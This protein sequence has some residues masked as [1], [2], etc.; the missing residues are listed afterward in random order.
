[1]I[2]E[3]LDY[4]TFT[5]SLTSKAQSDS[6]NLRKTII[7]EFR[8]PLTAKR[9]LHG[10]NEK[11]TSLETGADSIRIDPELSAQYGMDI[12]RINYEAMAILYTIEKDE[13]LIQRIIAQSL[14][15]F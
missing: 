1:M 5:I 2:S 14:V 11:I 8:A 4:K 15:K 13:V 12:R 9:Y 3:R 6:F 10:L 7:F